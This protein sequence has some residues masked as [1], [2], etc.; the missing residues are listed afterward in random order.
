MDLAIFF[1][2]CACYSNTSLEGLFIRSLS[3]NTKR[4]E[5]LFDRGILCCIGI[6]VCFD[7]SEV[8]HDCYTCKSV[9]R[10]GL[11]CKVPTA[12]H[13]SSP[14]RPHKSYPLVIIITVP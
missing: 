6:S 3:K 11:V 1:R 7:S 2:L 5:G 10:L 4:S 9:V 14:D 13:R 8:K 12:S